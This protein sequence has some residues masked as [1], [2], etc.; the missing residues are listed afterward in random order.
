MKINL[1]AAQVRVLDRCA[2]FVIAD[3]WP[4]DDI[5]PKLLERAVAAL[6][7]E[8]S[9]TP[10]EDDLATAAALLRDANPVNRQWAE[11]RDAFL[12][13]IGEFKE[14]AE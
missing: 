6:R 13:S 7:G 10:V 11:K 2:Q 4:W 12:E 1:T 8:A 14:P 3:E 5:S 9:P